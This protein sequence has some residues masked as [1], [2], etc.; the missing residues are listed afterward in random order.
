LDGDAEVSIDQVRRLL[1][2]LAAKVE[3]PAHDRTML[4][5][6]GTPHEVE[7]F[8]KISKESATWA[9]R[10]KR[11]KGGKKVEVVPEEQA[12]MV[13]DLPSTKQ[14][15]MPGLMDKVQY[16][17]SINAA[18]IEYKGLL[19]TGSKSLGKYKTWRDKVYDYAQREIPEDGAPK[20]NNLPSIE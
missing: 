14:K 12:P 17:D 8:K 15:L 5:M 18:D 6:L 20:V 7:L 10:V 9:R 4:D 1:S 3:D 2:D 13:N 11:E 19:S 16:L